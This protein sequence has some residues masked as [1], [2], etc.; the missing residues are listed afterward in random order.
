VVCYDHTE[1]IVWRHLN[2]FE[3]KCVSEHPKC[4]T[5]VRNRVGSKCTT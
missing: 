3:H 5:N 2:V 4:T 1:E